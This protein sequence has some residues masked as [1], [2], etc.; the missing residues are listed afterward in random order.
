MFI[1]FQTKDDKSI[2]YNVE[3]LVFVGEMGEDVSVMFEDG[4][5]ALFPDEYVS[6]VKRLIGLA[7]TVANP[8]VYMQFET[9]K[10]ERIAFPIRRVFYILELKETTAIMF[11]DGTRIEVLDNYSDVME[12]IYKRIDTALIRT[13][14]TD[15]IKSM[16]KGAK[17]AKTVDN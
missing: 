4:T 7:K 6:F 14:S 1:E 16:E 3:K 17:G 5:H 10:H 2:S 13:N 9:K 12:R 8:S 11:D 15:E